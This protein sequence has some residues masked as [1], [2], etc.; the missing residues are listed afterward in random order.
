MRPISRHRDPQLFRS[1]ELCFSLSGNRGE[2]SSG[3]SRGMVFATFWSAEECSGDWPRAEFDWLQCALVIGSPKPSPWQSP[4]SQQLTGQ[5]HGQIALEDEIGHGAQVL[6]K[7]EGKWEVGGR[8]G[9]DDLVDDVH[10]PVVSCKVSLDHL[11][12]FCCHYLWRGASTGYVML[13]ASCCIY[14]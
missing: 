2:Y 4:K 11:G 12:P 10:Q 1:V 14:T 5:C 7:G 13:C 6:V 9:V 8:E 3:F